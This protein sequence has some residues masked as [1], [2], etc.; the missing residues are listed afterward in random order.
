M[1]RR[2]PE[3]EIND[4]QRRPDATTEY[5]LGAIII[6]M[7]LAAALIVAGVVFIINQVN[8]NAPPTPTLTLS[9]T[10]QYSATPSDT[11]TETPTATFTIT[12]IPT[13]TLTPRPSATITP[14][15]TLSPTPTITDTPAPTI[16]LRPSNTRDVT[17]DTFSPGDERNVRQ[18]NF[19]SG[20]PLTVYWTAAGNAA[21]YRV[22]LF[23][24]SGSEIWAVDTIDAPGATQTDLPANVFEQTGTYAWE[25]R[26][27]NEQNEQICP[28][29]GIDLRVTDQ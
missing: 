10:P 9:P 18:Y 27:F 13:W 2:P 12:D 25:V 1:D 26:A 16:T 20:E 11:P 23:G 19:N 6:V 24:P 28:A 29:T 5:N 8:Q 14:T 22:F 3:E 17:C 15:T 21:F 7:V 4:S